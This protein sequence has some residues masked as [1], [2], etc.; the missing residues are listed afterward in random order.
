[1]FGTGLGL[2]VVFPQSTAVWQTPVHV[3][4]QGFAGELGLHNGRI[5]L[6]SQKPEKV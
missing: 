1:M 2:V 5:G 6:E 4:K 3:G